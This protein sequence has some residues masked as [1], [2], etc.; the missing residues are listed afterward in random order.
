M[1]F[2]N[3]FTK[4]SA[5]DEDVKSPG[6]PAFTQ[7]NWTGDD[8]T[9]CG[10]K[11]KTQ[12][13]QPGPQNKKKRFYQNHTKTNYN[14]N[15]FNAEAGGGRQ[16]STD[17]KHA[18]G[19]F[20]KQVTS[21]PDGKDGLN[22]RH[23]KGWNEKT[24][25]SFHADE[26]QQRGKKKTQK[27]KYKHQRQ[28]GRRDG[29]EDGR[30]VMRKG[31]RGERR[32][33]G[34]QTDKLTRTRF[35]SQEFKDQ[36]AVMVDG[37]L[38][39]RHFLWGR[40][41]KAN[42]CQL[43]HVQSF[44]GLLKEVC[45][46]Y[47]Q[48]F[49]T[50][51]ESC[52]YMHKSFPC[53]FFHRKGKCSQEADCKFSHEPLNDVT[54][55][56]FEETLKRDTDYALAKKAE[57]EAAAQ[58]EISE[59]SEIIEAN[60]TSDVVTQPLRL[61]FY[62]TAGKIGGEETS[63]QTE[64][65][66]D[67]AAEER[68]HSPPSTNQEEPVSYSVEAVL[69]PQLSRPFLS[70]YTTP[71]S[72][73]STTV[74]SSVATLGYANQSEAP[75]SVDAV[76]RSCKSAENP[77]FGPRPV[78]STPKTDLEENPDLLHSSQ[79]QIEKDSLNT[80]DQ[81]TKSQVKMFKSL[82]F[83]VTQNTEEQAEATE[84][85]IPPRALEAARPH[86]PPSTNLEEPVCYSVEAVLGPQGSR[87]FPSF[88]TTPGSQES[89]TVPSSDATLGY[90]NQSEAPYS[91][92]AVLRSCKSVE[93]LTFGQ[94]PAALTEN[95][96]PLQS[97]QHRNEKDSLNT[98]DE[99]S[100]SRQKI[101]K[102]LL[103]FE[104]QKICP[105]LSESLK[106]PRRASHGVTEADKSGSTGCSHLPAGTACS[107]NSKNEGV[108]R[109]GRPS[110]QTCAPKRPAHTKPHL[111]VWTFHSQ[112]SVQPFL[113]SEGGGAVPVASAGRSAKTNDSAKSAITE[114]RRR[115]KR[116]QSGL[117]LGAQRQNSPESKSECSSSL[118]NT[119]GCHQTQ[120]RPFHSLFASPISDGVISASP[121]RFIQ[122]PQSAD[123]TGKDGEV[124]TA[125][126]PDKTS[127]AS[128]FSL[129]ATPLK[130]SAASHSS[131]RSQADDS[132]TRPCGQ[133]L[134]E[135][136]FQLSGSKQQASDSGA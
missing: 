120:K 68:P 38:L 31:G 47:V 79:T 3:L 82:P 66:A 113:K 92:D 10:R 13:E 100:K 135:S 128:F 108:F 51:G 29:G 9:G 111:P 5:G 83:F 119:N 16:Q 48:G 116:T 104:V 97:S 114:M 105:D 106:T 25:N 52:P 81:E 30:H 18:M 91:V 27:Q 54:K 67:I 12:W 129:F 122:P 101:F 64:E 55:R 95:T 96:D 124:Q 23:C 117:K 107:V 93:N 85:V 39:C 6:Q 21:H 94:R 24:Q 80:G 33:G 11:R 32:N 136:T 99:A 22:S 133:Q 125:P 75:Y 60:P 77:T 126:E 62:S 37:R 103:S 49:C 109:F 127:A 73:E 112:S 34:K 40:C 130:G 59:E 42:E 71:G 44:N 87:P 26:R 118:P 2:A 7:W 56:L 76:L 65:Q 131:R 1:A 69:G 53:K 72:Q 45:K 43:E 14:Y 89:T 88:L 90:V 123:F 15:S 46:F 41:I 58:P 70:F 84:E 35:M 102:S 57:Q 74:P 86:S 98:G 134:A 20:T 50:K 36:N 8:P 19:G 78:S 63:R 4:L 17:G 115:S 28:N 132:K 121:R 61:N 110:G